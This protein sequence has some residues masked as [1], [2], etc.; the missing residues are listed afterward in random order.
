MSTKIY[1]GYKMPMLN[2]YEL[3]EFW[4]KVR[5]LL[6]GRREELVKARIAK[7]FIALFDELHINDKLTPEAY[8]KRFKHASFWHSR[9]ILSLIVV[10]AAMK[11]KEVSRTM[12][13]DPAYDFSFDVKVAP[14]L[15]KILLNVFTDRKEFM[16]I[17]KRLPEVEFYG[18]WDNVEPQEDVSP[19]EWDQRKEDWDKAYGKSE[20]SRGFVLELFYKDQVYY[21]FDS[22][23]QLL[24]YLPDYEP[25]LT[26][27]AIQKAISHLLEKEH[28]RKDVQVSD[29]VAA[30]TKV[31]NNPELVEAEKPGIH[32]VKEITAEHLMMNYE[33]VK[34]LATV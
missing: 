29:Y 21:D 12:R 13:R 2:A 6:L 25:R 33:Q 28:G 8:A 18:Y 11:Q 5:S 27:I 4:E 34:A 10:E 20:I 14:I 16:E 24:T 26:K 23:E 17:W 30:N 32:I 15:D 3:T 31:R 1:S 19:E 22:N 7:D 9:D